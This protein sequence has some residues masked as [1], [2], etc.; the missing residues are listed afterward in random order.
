MLQSF[1]DQLHEI[2]EVVNYFPAEA[3]QAVAQQLVD[4]LTTEYIGGFHGKYEGIF[5]ERST[6]PPD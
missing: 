6:E 3:R 1:R 5:K 4:K 2:M